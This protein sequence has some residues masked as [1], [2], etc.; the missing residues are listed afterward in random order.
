MYWPLIDESVNVFNDRCDNTD[1]NR[2]CNFCRRNF[3]VGLRLISHKCSYIC[4]H[5]T[6]AITK[7]Y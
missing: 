7:I 1:T 5:V 4:Q 6:E 2:H 3:I